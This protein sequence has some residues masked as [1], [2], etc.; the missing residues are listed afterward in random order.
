MHFTD[1]FRAARWV[2]LINLLLQAAFFLTLFAG[3][4]YIALNH[5]WRFDVTASRRYS[6]SP[7]TRSYLDHLERDVTIVVTVTE[8][9]DS[10]EIAQAYRDISGLL[11]EYVYLTR[12]RP[13]G[14]IQVR[15]VDVYQN[16]REAKALGVEQPN[17]VVLQSDRGRSVKT[18][19]DLYVIKKKVSR[20]AFRG[21]AVITAAI[22]DVAS[23]QKTKIYFL[24]GHGEMSPDSVDG[25]RGLSLLRDQ[26]RQR[27]FELEGINLSLTKRIPEDAALLVIA[28][29][30]GRIPP[31]EEEL[32]RT[33]L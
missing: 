13:K 17:V 24:A 31:L 10:D 28:S 8:T 6:L 26:L 18:L 29:P 19:E 21:E 32:L 3:L 16:R 25:A 2:R 33:F 22:L 7:E 15:Y 12:D 4:N 5:S 23:A 11:R 14:R 27:N 9:S 20:E 30:Q 1:S